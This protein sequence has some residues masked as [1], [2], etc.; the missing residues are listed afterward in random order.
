MKLSENSKKIIELILSPEW[1]E[2]IAPFLICSDTEEDKQERAEGILEY[3][4]FDLK[5][6]KIC[7]YGCGEGHV[8]LIANKKG[9]D[10]IGYDIVK[11]G[12][13]KWDCNENFILT[14]SYDKILHKS[15]F[16]V[17]ILY[18][19]LDHCKDPED[20]LEKIKKIS[21]NKTKIF[22]RC[23]SW[24]SRHGG[25]IYKQ[26]NK[27]WVHLFLNENELK[28]IGIN[29]EFIYKT[30]NPTEIQKK[31]FNKNFSIES[32][33][34]IKTIIEPFFENNDLKKMILKNNIKIEDLNL[35]MSTIFNDYVLTKKTK[36]LL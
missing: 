9:L 3:V 8:S 5:D 11:T 6:K 4:P 2:A 25:H 18:D 32:S 14:T 7:D 23:H 24:M 22:V 21:N 28:N 10:C 34:T 29:Q 1:P 30:F 31:W 26:L 33:D 27:A 13:H 17:I 20:V 12:I 15:P 35:E 36:W 16:D 19:V